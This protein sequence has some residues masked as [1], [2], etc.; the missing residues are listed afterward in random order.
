MMRLKTI[1][2]PVLLL[3]GLTGSALALHFLPFGTVLKSHAHA[4]ASV[5][6]VALFIGLGAVACAVG[7]PRQIVAFAAGYAWGAALGTTMAL[8]AQ[9]I[10]CAAD[11]YW[12]RWVARDFVQ[13]RL[14]GSVQRL[15]RMLTTTPFIASLTLR[16]MPVGN[17]LLLNLLAGVSAVPARG[18]LLGSAVG[19]IPQTVIFA[20]LGSGSRIAR[21][22]QIE[23]GVSLF[24]IS[25]AIGVVLLMRNRETPLGVTHE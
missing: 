5:P 24:V 13:A 1:A 7:I 19:Y 14:R 9:I 6:D 12:A 23:V 16:L 2:K 10:G 4:H 21:G 18:F 15:D 17:N 20:L 8:G 22:T 3:V 25:M 11:L